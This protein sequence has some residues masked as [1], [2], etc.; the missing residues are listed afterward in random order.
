MVLDKKAA[1]A[2]KGR[3]LFRGSFVGVGPAASL[4]RFDFR[5]EG[6]LKVC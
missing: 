6:G 3:A 4:R 5:V 1:G 2:K